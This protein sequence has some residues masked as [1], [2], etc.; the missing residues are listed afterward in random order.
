[1][2]GGYL[3]FYTG[4]MKYLDNGAQLAGVMAHEIAHADRRHSTENMTKIY[5]INILLSILLGNNDS[6]L[7]E[8]GAQL[9]QGS[10]QLAFSRNHEYEADEFAVRYT[11][12]TS[13][14]PK[15]V[16]GFF[17]KLE[18]ENATR[19]PEFLSTHP[20]P[21]NRIEA[22]DEVWATLG[23]PDGSWEDVPYADFLQTL[24]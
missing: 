10:A 9:A 5:G 13:F 19:T 21:D 23:S 24:P 20:N 6:Q 22:I 16:A 4:M 18:D 15:G 2:P 11:T 7:V 3:Y 12:Q 8:I 14:H 1:A 17:E